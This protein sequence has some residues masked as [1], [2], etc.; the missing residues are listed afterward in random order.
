M[1]FFVYAETMIASDAESEEDAK[2]EARQT[3]IERLLKNE[4]EWLVEEEE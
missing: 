2:E 4:V 1:T 3:L